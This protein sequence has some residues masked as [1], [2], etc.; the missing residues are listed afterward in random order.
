MRHRHG[1]RK[2][3][4]TGS[5]RKAMLQSLCN[6]LIEHEAIRTTLPKAKELR[7]VLEPLVTVA[8]KDNSVANQR[9][10]FS[11]LRN[12]TNVKKLFDDI[13]PRFKDRPGG[14]IRVLKNGFRTGDAAP[15]AFVEFVERNRD[16][17]TQK[18]AKAKKQ[19][20]VTETEELLEDDGDELD[21]ANLPEVSTEEVEVVEEE[22]SEDASTEEEKKD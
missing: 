22:T 14:Y 16:D 3:N 15:M 4:V 10:V 6:A 9:L 17:E 11:K 7:K 19:A 1:L 2:L 8:R 20:E 12:K 5:H 21:A 13:G 18:V